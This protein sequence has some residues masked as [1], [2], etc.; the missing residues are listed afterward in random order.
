MHDKEQEIGMRSSFAMDFLPYPSRSYGNVPSMQNRGRDYHI[1]RPLW[2]YIDSS[3]LHV[4]SDA[5]DTVDVTKKALRN[6]FC[7][8][9]L[10]KKS[11]SIRLRANILPLE[12]TED[13]DVARLPGN[14]VWDVLF[15]IASA[16]LAL[17][18]PRYSGDNREMILKTAEDARSR[19][20]SLSSS[21]KSRP[22]RLKKRFGW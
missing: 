19:L 21:Q 13:G 1:D 3:D 7:V 16:N 14:V 5:V 18:D 2:Y 9:P 6:R 12:L 11:Q 17:S 10:P 22:V 8:Y 20:R 15:P 4:Y